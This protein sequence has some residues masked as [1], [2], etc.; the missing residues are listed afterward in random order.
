VI[1]KK[2]EATNAVDF[3]KYAEIY[4]S[5]EVK[6]FI[7]H[8][9]KGFIYILGLEIGNNPVGFLVIERRNGLNH[10]CNCFFFLPEFRRP[11]YENVLI[12]HGINEAKEEGAEHFYISYFKDNEDAEKLKNL[13]ESFGFKSSGYERYTF[14]MDRGEIGQAI[15]RLSIKYARYLNLNGK[16]IRAFKDLDSQTIQLINSQRGKAFPDYFY[17]LSEYY[18]PECSTM[19]CLDGDPAGWM[20]FEAY[21]KSALY[22]YNIFIKEK[23]RNKGLFVPILAFAYKHTPE[24]V[25]RYFFYVNGDN[26]NMLGLLR[27]F[28]DCLVKKDVLI[29]MVK[30]LKKT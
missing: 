5:R 3:L 2:F 28:P 27:L 19:I 22:V 17:P 18:C 24:T 15:Q 9:Y 7:D 20:V 8:L 25:K 21:D 10:V 12:Q 30:A 14:V 11:S 4:S 13:Y 23:Y 29:E 1:I 26:H 6:R 16:K